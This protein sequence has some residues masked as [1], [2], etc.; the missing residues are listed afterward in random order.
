VDDRRVAKCAEILELSDRCTTIFLVATLRLQNF[1]CKA[2]AEVVRSG[3]H[4]A[5]ETLA[6]IQSGPKR[7]GQTTSIA[8]DGLA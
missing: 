3:I 7:I 8:F 5:E 4:N 1:D 2:I 6:I